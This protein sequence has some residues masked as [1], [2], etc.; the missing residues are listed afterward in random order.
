MRAWL[1]VLVSAAFPNA[2]WQPTEYAG[3]AGPTLALQQGLDDICT[4][5]AAG[6]IRCLF[7]GGAC[8]AVVHGARCLVPGARCLMPVPVPVHADM[9]LAVFVDVHLAVHVCVCVCVCVLGCVFL[10]PYVPDPPCR[11]HT[12]TCGCFALVAL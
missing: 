4:S 2:D 3:C 5:V 11:S 1:G 9:P 7:R 12:R 6:L 10:V 8:F